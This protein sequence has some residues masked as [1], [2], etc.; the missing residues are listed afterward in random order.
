VSAILGPCPLHLDVLIETRKS[1]NRAIE[2][3]VS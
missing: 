1:P 3:A 2:G